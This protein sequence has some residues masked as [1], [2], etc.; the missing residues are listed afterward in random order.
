MVGK[1]DVQVNPNLVLK[2]VLPIPHLS[3]NLV[4]KH[5]VTQDLTSHIIFD[6]SFFEFQDQSLGRK[7]GLD[8]EHNG[9][10]YL[11]TCSQSELVKS[12]Y[13]LFLRQIKMSFGYY[14]YHD[15]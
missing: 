13:F 5:K 10:Y 1:G 8:K 7:I 15:L 4:S 6:A 9:L 14:E 11:S 12:V 2:N 3:T